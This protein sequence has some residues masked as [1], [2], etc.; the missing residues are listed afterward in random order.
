MNTYIISAYILLIVLVFSFKIQG[1]SLKPK[2]ENEKK[3]DEIKNKFPESDY[4][5]MNKNVV[6][7]FSIDTKTGNIVVAETVE[8]TYLFLKD[9][10]PFR[11]DILI[12][13][14][15]SVLRYMAKD[16]T[17]RSILGDASTTNVNIS[18]IFYSDAKKFSFYSNVKK[19]SKKGSVVTYV[20]TTKCTDSKYYSS[21]YLNDHYPL[22]DYSLMIYKP[23]WLDIELKEYN[24][25]DVNFSSSVREQKDKSTLYEYKAKNLHPFE[26][27]SNMP[28]ISWNYPH[29]LL[30][31]K[32]Y[33]NNAGK[34]VEL[35]NDTRSLYSWYKSLVDQVKNNPTDYAQ[36]VDK[37]IASA[38]TDIEKINSIFNW[39]Q[40][41]IRY[42]AFENGIMGFKPSTAQ[43]VYNK[44][45]GDCKG[46]ANLLKAM[47]S[48]AGYDARLTW[49]GTVGKPYNYSVPSLAVDNH[50]ICTVFL[51]GTHLYLD[52]TE[53]YSSINMQTERIQG[54]EVMI[55]NG[56]DF[57]IDIIPTYSPQNNLFKTTGN[58]KAEGG[59]LKGNVRY[60]YYGE[61]KTEFLRG[62]NDLK[63]QIKE[64][65]LIRYLSNNDKN[66]SVSNVNYNNVTDFDKDLIFDFDIE[67][68]NAISEF[69]G[70]LYVNLEFNREFSRLNI[71]SLRFSD[72][73]F[74]SKQHLE[75]DIS[76]TI[77]DG[78]EVTHLP[79]KVQYSNDYFSFLLEMSQNKRGI[80]EYT[81]TITIK[82]PLL[83]RK[84]F[85][86][87]NKAVKEARAFYQDQIVLEK[88]KN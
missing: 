25:A 68:S 61:E 23:E 64:Q 26:K 13:S 59:L 73:F 6:V 35:M 77:P 75:S 42:I 41:N 12:D 76:F 87:W 4:A 53:T 55:E 17:G 83:S 49:V 67:I 16:L 7:K 48:H 1:Q 72:Y 71:D 15:T 58:I 20:Y 10:I 44:R 81:K 27:V 33:K 11:H 69:D 19:Y 38:S 8:E 2:P 52:P 82:N 54:R 88:I 31:T 21:I 40:H 32:S 66:I 18:G 36:Q 85:S 9:Y 5:L 78:Y 37:L 65:A 50:M 39:V 45:Y 57:I 30:I 74:G 34:K 29:L 79:A 84:M 63:T 3:A 56:K 24:L 14:T 43:Y 51:N 46:M 28:L 22:I 80:V 47:L 86:E 70:I 62:Y 60:S